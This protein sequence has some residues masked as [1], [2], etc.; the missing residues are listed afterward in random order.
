ML[1]PAM[2]ERFALPYIQRFCQYLDRSIY[3]LDGRGQIEHVDF[4]LDMEELDGIQWSAQ[5]TPVNPQYDAIQWYP[6]FQRIQNAGKILY[7]DAQPENVKRLVNDLSPEG[8]FLNVSCNSEKQLK[9]LL[10]E[11][12]GMYL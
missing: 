4:L 11:I 7:I 9:E 5:I 3:H 8:L 1:S 6:Y 2:F 10:D 12:Y